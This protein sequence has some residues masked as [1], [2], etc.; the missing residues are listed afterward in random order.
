MTTKAKEIAGQI[1]TYIIVVILIV[2]SG[3]AC[4][5]FFKMWTAANGIL[6]HV[7]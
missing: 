7:H 2:G 3:S 5:G 1:V 4:G 6:I